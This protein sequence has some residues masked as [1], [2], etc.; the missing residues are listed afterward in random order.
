MKKSMSGFLFT[1]ITLF[2]L[3]SVSFAA[4]D[5]PEFRG[6]FGNGYVAMPGDAKPVGL[7][8]KW[9]ESENI[10]WKT[11]IHDAGWS[12][13]VIMGGQVWLT[14]ATLDGKDFFAVCIDGETGKILFNEKL[15]HCDKP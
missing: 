2:V 5:W 15:F 3:S 8:L 13:P 7:P 11:E 14:T 6:P 1:G 4:T 10:K 12:T 9:D